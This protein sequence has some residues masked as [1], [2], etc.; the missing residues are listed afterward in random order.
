MVGD[1]HWVRS[2]RERER[3]IPS[4]SKCWD[5][6]WLRSTLCVGHNSRHI[7]SVLCL[8]AFIPL[9]IIHNFLIFCPLILISG[10][11]RQAALYYAS[12]YVFHCFFSLHPFDLH[13]T[14]FSPPGTQLGP[15]TWALCV[16]VCASPPFSL[17]MKT[18][19]ISET[20]ITICFRQHN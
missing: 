8:F 1:V 13:L 2:D 12:P 11:L 14:F 7:T 5:L 17:R 19:P 3:A 4:F 16:C 10:A 20:L 15:K 18:D 9:S 6:Q